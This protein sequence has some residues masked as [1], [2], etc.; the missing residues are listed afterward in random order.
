MRRRM[1]VAL[2]DATDDYS[3]M[4]RCIELLAA[5][6]IGV[7]GDVTVGNFLSKLEA[8]LTGALAAREQAEQD[9][10]DQRD[11]EDS[12]DER[13]RNRAGNEPGFIA[14]STKRRKALANDS[15][16]IAD[17][18]LGKPRETV[19]MTRDQVQDFI[20]DQEAKRFLRGG[21]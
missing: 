16:R 17:Q 13:F 19:G 3:R 11:F 12:E 6:G 14:M 15:D 5:Y 18:V 10:Q 8:S 7:P 1:A 2:P 21:K 20:A 9:A 4:T